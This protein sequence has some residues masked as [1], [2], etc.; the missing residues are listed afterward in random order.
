MTGFSQSLQNRHAKRWKPVQQNN[1]GKRK[2]KKRSPEK[3]KL[4]K[5]RE[6]KYPRKD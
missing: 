1:T 2:L 3:I 6:S 5:Q 4:D